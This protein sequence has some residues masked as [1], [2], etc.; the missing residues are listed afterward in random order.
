LR[1]EAG[2][3]TG[4][5]RRSTAPKKRMKK[6]CNS[7]ALNQHTSSHMTLKMERLDSSSNSPISAEEVGA[8][9]KKQSEI[10][11]KISFE[12]IIALNE[13]NGFLL[14]AD[15]D[16]LKRKDVLKRREVILSDLPKEERDELLEIL[17]VRHLTQR[18]STIH[19][20]AK[21]QKVSAPH[22][23]RAGGNQPRTRGRHSTG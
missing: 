2:K 17:G 22:E 1:R 9:L 7:D 20:Y 8:L 6:D 12:K 13:V 11:R 15:T 21:H 16:I 5:D 14:I 3:L 19:S 23:P 10:L 18:M 4:L